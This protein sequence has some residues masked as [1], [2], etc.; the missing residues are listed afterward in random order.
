MNKFH[1]VQVL[2]LLS[3]CLILILGAVLLTSFLFFESHRQED[4]PEQTGCGYIDYRPNQYDDLTLMDSTQIAGKLI[5]E[6]NCSACHSQSDE[7]VIGPGLKGIT[8]RRSKQWIVE[9]VQNPQ[10]ILHKGDKYALNLYE[11]FNKTEMPAFGKLSKEDIAAI[12]SY[13]ERKPF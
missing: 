10:K 1:I 12:V 8:E 5:F 9:W 6:Q 2:R 11:K 13:V 7:V 4:Q 3:L